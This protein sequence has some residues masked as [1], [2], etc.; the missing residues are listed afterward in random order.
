MPVKP[1]RPC[2]HIGCSA[3]V[4]SGYC[5]KHKHNAKQTNEWSDMYNSRRWRKARLYYLTYN[6]LCVECH[7]QGRLITARVV[8]HIID[9]KGNY[10]LFWNQDNWQAL[11]ISCHNSKTARTNA[12]YV[13]QRKP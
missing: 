11:C 8:D 3:I 4:E 7:K 9:H 10:E 12:G 5:N 6:P 2:K 1:K 13:Q